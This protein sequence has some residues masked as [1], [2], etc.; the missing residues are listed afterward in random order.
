MR[1][2]PGFTA[3]A[4]LTLGVGMG[5]SAAM[6]SLVDT[7][8][9]RPL[10]YAEPKRLV[11]IYEGTTGRAV[12]A[13]SEYLAFAEQTHT[14]EAVAAIQPVNVTVLGVEQTEQVS[15]ALVS[16]SMFP[17]LGIQPLLGRNFLPDEDRPGAGQAA[18]ISEGLW[19]RVYGSDPLIAGKTITLD[20]SEAW[21]RPVK[22]SKAYTVAGVLPASFETL[23]HGI[24]GDVWLPLAADRIDSHD[25]FVVGRM[26]PGI[27]APQVQSDLEA[28]AAPMRSLRPL[29]RPRHALL[30][31]PAPHG[32]ARRLAARAARAHGRGRIG[33][34]HRVRERCQPAPG[35]G[36]GAQPRAR[37]TRRPRRE[38]RPSATP[39]PRG[40]DAPLRGRGWN[41]P[42]RRTRKH[43]GACPAGASKCGPPRSGPARSARA[44]VHGGDRDACRGTRRAPAGV[45]A[46]AIE[47]AADA[48]GS[49]ARRRRKPRQPP[50]SVGAGH[51]RGRTRDHP[52]HRR[53]PD[54]EDGRRVDQRRSWLQNPECPQLP[55]LPAPRGESDASSSA[56]ISTSG[57]SRASG[58][59]RE[60]RPSASTTRC[61]LAGS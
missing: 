39:D 37:R 24:R 36:L 59:F 13:W 48:S 45:P 34:P 51:R 52:A 4:V 22:R 33:T 42:A 19:Q 14:L 17:L 44:R 7:V 8:L 60:S 6:F 31:R 23:L 49:R 43:L 57:C 26:K 16:A 53:R 50:D 46:R 15:G 54:V 2:A 12:V 30:D 21:G 10:P 25:L 55:D 32:P 3:V 1:R 29:R 58:L 38:P 18:L 5:V 27:S 35:A 9:L 56:R 28:I 61:R 20:V 47:P 40:D 41:R 11:S